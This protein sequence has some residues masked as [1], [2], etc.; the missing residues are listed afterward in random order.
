MIFIGLVF[1]LVVRR[2]GSFFSYG[3]ISYSRESVL[4]LRHVAELSGM[5]FVEYKGFEFGFDHDM[6]AR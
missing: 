6:A 2:G 1:E 5:F 3:S 4:L